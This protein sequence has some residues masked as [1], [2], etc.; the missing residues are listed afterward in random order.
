MDVVA[1]AAVRRSEGTPTALIEAMACGIPVV[2]T[3]VGGVSDIVDDRR[4]GRVVAPNRPDAFGVA[5]IE[6]L[7]NHA[8]ARAMGV[9]AREQVLDT[10]S[11]EHCVKAHIRA[12]SLALATRQGVRAGAG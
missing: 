6:V 2:A 1:L 5:L 11:I 8:E 4:T 9:A 12:Y 7:T 10:F 3:D